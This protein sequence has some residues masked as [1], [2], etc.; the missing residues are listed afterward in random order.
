[1]SKASNHAEIGIRLDGITDQ[2]RNLP[3][4]FAEEL[5]LSPHGGFAIDV[6]GSSD[7][8]G[9]LLQR[10]ALTAQAASVVLKRMHATL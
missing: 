7:V 9:N 5:N 6:N 8:A 4:G 10:H 2:M 1:L 3:E